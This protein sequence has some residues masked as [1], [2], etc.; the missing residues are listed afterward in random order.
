MTGMRRPRRAPLERAREALAQG[1]PSAAV[2][3]GWAAAIAGARGRKAE[4]LAGTRALAVELR[5]GGEGRVQ[6]DARGLAIYCDSALNQIESGVRERSPLMRM[7]SREPR[8]DPLK[9]C[10]DCAESVQA[11][12]R[13]CRFCGYEFAPPPSA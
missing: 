4:D 10:P 11:A 6:E 2:R 12:A 5:D 13:V 7:L 8:T 9:V 3:Y 1:D